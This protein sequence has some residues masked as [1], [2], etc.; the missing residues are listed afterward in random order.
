MS[1]WIFRRVGV[2][3]EGMFSYCVGEWSLV[4]LSGFDLPGRLGRVNIEKWLDE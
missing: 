3:G 1:G 4:D 2:G